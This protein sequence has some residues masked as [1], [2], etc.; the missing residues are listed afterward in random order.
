MDRTSLRA[1][2]ILEKLRHILRGRSEGPQQS[3]RQ[4]S[5]LYWVESVNFFALLLPAFGN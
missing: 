5:L 1:W 4:L 2:G 3:T